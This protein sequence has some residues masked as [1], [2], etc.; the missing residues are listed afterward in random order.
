M[1]ATSMRTVTRPF[2]IYQPIT[3]DG[4]GDEG[5][6]SKTFVPPSHSESS[7]P[8]SPPQSPRP[9]MT[10]LR[11]FWPADQPLPVALNLRL[12]RAVTDATLDALTEPALLI[13]AEGEDFAGC[14]FSRAISLG[15]E[16]G[17]PAFWKL[18][19]TSTD[20]WSLCL[21]RDKGVLAAYNLR[22]KKNDSFPMKLKRGVVNKTFMK[23]PPTI[24][25]SQD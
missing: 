25:I 6:G 20:T 10:H 12:D 3:S 15:D 7:K 17:S 18:E 9:P 21:R 4:S 2:P 22:R 19:K 24:T 16:A 5:S 13:H 1:E 23:W 8:G 14:W 11:R